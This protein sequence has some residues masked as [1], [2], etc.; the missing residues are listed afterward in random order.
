M[1]VIFLTPGF[2]FHRN[3]KKSQTLVLPRARKTLKT[4][5]ANFW[6]VRYIQRLVKDQE[7]KIE[8]AEDKILIYTMSKIQPHIIYIVG[9]M[10][11]PS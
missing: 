8:E 6:Y 4:K 2:N 7:L 1:S 11:P 5:T 3:F 10:I 9:D